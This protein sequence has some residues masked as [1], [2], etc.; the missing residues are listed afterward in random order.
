[1]PAIDWSPASTEIVRS[2]VRKL[3]LVMGV[4]MQLSALVQLGVLGWHLTGGN[5]SRRATEIY[6]LGLGVP[7]LI[8]LAIGVLVIRAC[9]ERKS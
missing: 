6:L 5:V 3:G 1:M 9:R 7:A 8:M 2:G 4:L